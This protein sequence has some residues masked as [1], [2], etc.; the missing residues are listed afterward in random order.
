VGPVMTEEFRP[1]DWISIWALPMDL[2]KLL[3]AGIGMPSTVDFIIWA[4]N[5]QIP[6]T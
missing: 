3:P 2:G 1:Q 5:E 6:A 4:R